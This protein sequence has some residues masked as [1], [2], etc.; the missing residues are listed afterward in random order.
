MAQVPTAQIDALVKQ[1]AAALGKYQ[2]VRPE[3]QNFV[4]E[5][6]K[7]AVPAQIALDPQGRIDQL[8]RPS[9]DVFV[10]GPVATDIEWWFST[11]ELC[12]LMEQ[13]Q[14]LLLMSINPGLANPTDWQRIAYKGG[15]EPG[16]LNLTTYRGEKRQAPLRLSD[17]E[18]P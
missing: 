8:P 9:V 17:L 6:E 13:V 1:L 7:G 4:V 15:S 5:F 2:G 12:G 14:G 11:A 18:Q 16:V 3:G 10:G